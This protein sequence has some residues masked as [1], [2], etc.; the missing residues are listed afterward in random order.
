MTAT[1]MTFLDR[2]AMV[3]V[4]ILAGAPMLAIAARAAFL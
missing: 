3:F 1:F 2:T 4:V